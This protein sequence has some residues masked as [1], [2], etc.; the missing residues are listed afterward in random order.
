VLLGLPEFEMFFPR[1]VEET[2]SMLA[3]H[4]EDAQL[5]AGGTDLFV[6]MKQRR[7]VP[8]VLINIKRISG[9]DQIRWDAADGLHIGPLTTIQA[10]RDSAPVAERFPVLSEAAGVLGTAQVRN[11]GTIGGN[12][13]NASPSAEFAPPLLILDASVRCLGRRGERVV[14]L[15]GFFVGP[16]K[17]ALEADEVITDIQVPNP[18]ACQ[19]AGRPDRA[20]LVYL[21][22]SLRRM[23]VAMAAA[24]VMVLL[25]GDVCRDVRIALGAVAPTVFRARAAEQTLIGK[26]LTGDSRE[27]ELLE[28]AAQVAVGEARPIDDIRG[29]A[30]YRRKVVAM[31]VRHG[32]EHVIARARTQATE[33]HA[34]EA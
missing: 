25:D 29:Y 14:P 21:K 1:S 27:S 15:D 5:V 23:D 20:Q 6:K 2:S 10:I 7:L 18:P 19:G 12:L 13:G 8:S 31:L 34:N 28:E 11:L 17:S 24:A 22:H 26:R 9:L 3:K 32:L 16:G 4:G 30:S 33:R